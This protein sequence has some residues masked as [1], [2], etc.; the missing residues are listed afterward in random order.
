MI[1][2]ESYKNSHHIVGW[3]PNCTDAAKSD[4]IIHKHVHTTSTHPVVFAYKRRRFSLRLFGH[5]K[6]LWMFPYGLLARESTTYANYS[7]NYLK[8]WLFSSIS[9][10]FLEHRNRNRC[11]CKTGMDTLAHW[12]AAINLD[13]VSK[14]CARLENEQKIT[15]AFEWGNRYNVEIIHFPTYSFVAWLSIRATGQNSNKPNE[16]KRDRSCVFQMKYLHK[17]YSNFP[18]CDSMLHRATRT[19]VFSFYTYLV[20]MNRSISYRFVSD[21]TTEH[22]KRVE[23]ILF[24]LLLFLFNCVLIFRA[25]LKS[26]TKVT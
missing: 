11:D 18:L 21:R 17:S 20:Q 10:N 22:S 12:Q 4:V 3:Q 9:E 2:L 16:Y 26:T 24:L 25:N 15:N 19:A 6:C 13:K 5:S 7:V 14:L 8:I 23:R 1:N